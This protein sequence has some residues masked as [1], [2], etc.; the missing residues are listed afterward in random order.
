[1]L[2]GPVSGTL[3]GQPG[4]GRHAVSRANPIACMDLTQAG[5]LVPVRSATGSAPKAT[6][7]RFF[8]RTAVTRKETQW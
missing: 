8:G 2:A 3:K 6:V 5:Y 1:L 7:A 4:R